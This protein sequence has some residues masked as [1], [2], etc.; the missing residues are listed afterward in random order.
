MALKFGTFVSYILGKIP[1]KF[2]EFI[3][4]FK[5]VRENVSII[6]EQPSYGAFVVCQLPV[7]N[8]RNLSVI[9]IFIELRT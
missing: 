7:S 5:G 1:M 2:D 6:S 9:V 3:R 8:F 4:S